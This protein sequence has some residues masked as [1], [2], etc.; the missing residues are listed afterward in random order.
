[1]KTSVSRLPALGAAFLKTGDNVINFYYSEAEQL[2]F[3]GFLQEGL[4]RGSGVIIA[5]VG[6][7]HP[8]LTHGVHQPRL[9]RRRNMLRLQVTPNLHSSIAS[10]EQAAAALLQRTREIR[11]V[12]DFDGLVS[13]DA[14]FENEAQLNE[15]LRHKRAVVIS[16]YDGNA[17][18]APITMEQ[19]ETH[20][21]TLIGDA[22][23]SENRNWVA[24]SEYLQ[25]RRRKS[26]VAVAAAA[27]GPNFRGAA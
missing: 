15:A 16:Q 14:I 25:T 12:V 4:D 3:S 20:A 18:P 8:L 7:R 5:G 13:S 6:E 1:M 22:F 17:L 11:I 10:L 21:L 27:A 2:R 9:Q 26:Q 24:P 19:F 23:F